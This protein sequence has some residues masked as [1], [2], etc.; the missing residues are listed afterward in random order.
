[1]SLL[2]GR[3]DRVV[4][5]HLALFGVAAAGLAIAI[6]LGLTL[7]DPTPGRLGLVAA[8]MGIVILSWAGARPWLGFLI[9][10][11]SS[12]LLVVVL[13]TRTR[14][15]N[16]FDV[17]LPAVLLGTALRAAKPDPHRDHALE[18]SPAHEAI[19]GARRRFGVA[20]GLYFLVAGAS[21]VPG[22]VLGRAMQSVDSSLLLIRALQGASLYPIGMWWIRSRRRVNQTMGALFA[23]G[24]LLV[25]VNIVAIAAGTKRAGITW[26]VNIPSQ[27]VMGPNEAAAGILLLWV[28]LLARQSVRWR[29][30]NLLG[31]PVLFLMLILTQS[32]SGLLAWGTFNLLVLRRLGAR[33]V[34]FGLLAMALAL[35]F[36]PA[37]YMGRLS[38]TLALEPG[39]YEAYSALVRVYVWRAAAG[40]FRDHP[41]FGVGYLGFRFASGA[42]HNLPFV[43]GTCENI[44]L[45]IATGMGII[46]LGVAGLA[47]VRMFQ[48]GVVIRRQTRPGTLGH[49]LARY[50]TPFLVS[51]IVANLTADNWIGLTGLGQ[52][53]LWLL[54]LVRAGHFATPEQSA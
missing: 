6:A 19:R 42:Y 41:V 30:M 4:P 17:L 5:A 51:L 38:R 45:E 47:L 53:A 39:S 25:I 49:E 35:P 27:P 24:A 22:L 2:D 46:G 9:L 21:L 15:A 7:G 54:L 29:V 13:V 1:M 33:N 14:A 18:D 43:I 36:V 52:L 26:A 3:A 37:E 8:L 50:H 12:M 10:A 48:L 23:G 20:A 44:F 34:I 40:V 31:L 28:L 32:R 11:C 16:A